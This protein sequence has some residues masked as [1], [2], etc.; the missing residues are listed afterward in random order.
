LSWAGVLQQWEQGPQQ[1]LYASS[2]A[3]RVCKRIALHVPLA[4]N[5]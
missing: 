3:L 1:Q 5:I 2:E 4:C